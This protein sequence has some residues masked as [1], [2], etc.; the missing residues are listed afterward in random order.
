MY[1]NNY[2]IQTRCIDI[3]KESFL[4]IVKIILRERSCNEHK[5]YYTFLITLRILVYNTLKQCL[6]Q[7]FYHYIS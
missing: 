7:G 3:A 5:S 4:H 6:P 1:K 2:E